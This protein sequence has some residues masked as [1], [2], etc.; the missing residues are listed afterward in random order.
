MQSI[1][2]NKTRYRPVVII[3][4]KL[5]KSTNKRKPPRL[6]LPGA[7]AFVTKK[8]YISGVR[9]Y[10]LQKHDYNPTFKRYIP[11][12]RRNAPFDVPVLGR[13]GPLA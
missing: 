8:V 4:K 3:L 2:D 6:E 11:N 1:F 12:R 9:K 10:F 5:G 13:P 7:V